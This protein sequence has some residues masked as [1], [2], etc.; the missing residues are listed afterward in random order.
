MALKS[1]KMTSVPRRTFKPLPQ[2][3]QAKLPL[4]PSRANSL[5]S[6]VKNSRMRSSKK[7]ACG[8]SLCYIPPSLIL[9]AI[10]S[11]SLRTGTSTVRGCLPVGASRAIPGLTMAPLLLPSVCPESFSPFHFLD[12]LS[13]VPAF[14]CGDFFV[15]LNVMAFCLL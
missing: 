7:L 10:R 2:S 6:S 5:S 9:T 13:L 15:K 3:K 8:T 14:I 1:R 11:C 4:P 12:S